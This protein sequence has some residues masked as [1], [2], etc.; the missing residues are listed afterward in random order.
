VVASLNPIL[1]GWFG[2]FQHAHH[3]TFSTIDGFVRRRLRAV[4]RRRFHRPGLGHCQRDHNQWPNAYFADLWL[5]TMSEAHRLARQ[6][7]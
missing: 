7:R 1:Q 5:F 3:Y 6:S 2:Y 4:L